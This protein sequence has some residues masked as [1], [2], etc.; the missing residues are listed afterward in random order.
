MKALLVALSL[1]VSSSFAIAGVQ[2]VKGGDK[3]LAESLSQVEQVST[4]QTSDGMTYRVLTIDYKTG[5]DIRPY[6]LLVYVSAGGAI[7]GEAGYDQAF[8]VKLNWSAVDSVGV[9]GKFIV[10]RGLPAPGAHEKTILIRYVTSEQILS[11]Q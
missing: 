9:Q 6:S 11:V 10:V 2:P 1:F 8:V 5:A 4:R 7:G 3:D